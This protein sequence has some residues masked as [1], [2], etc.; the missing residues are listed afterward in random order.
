MDK[1]G[2]RRIAKLSALKNNDA[3][4]FQNE[5]AYIAEAMSNID[6]DCDGFRRDSICACNLRSDTSKKC[7]KSGIF[8]DSTRCRD[9][10]IIT[11]KI[12]GV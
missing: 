2:L 3:E 5:F 8:G 12:V 9:G 11:K 7:E 4:E 10:Y 1:S 6:A